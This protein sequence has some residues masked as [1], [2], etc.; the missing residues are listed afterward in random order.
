MSNS[1]ILEQKYSYGM[2]V[3]SFFPAQKYAWFLLKLE[4]ISANICLCHAYKKR[5]WLHSLQKH[6]I[7]VVNYVSLVSPYSKWKP[8]CSWKTDIASSSTLK[9]YFLERKFCEEK[10]EKFKERIVAAVCWDFAKK[11]FTFI[12]KTNKLVT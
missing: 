11:T 6:T 9:I 12:E 1:R 7:L 4:W 8:F 5:I 2:Q 10:N 3:F